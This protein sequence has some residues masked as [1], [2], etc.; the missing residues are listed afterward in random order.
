MIV[1][2]STWSHS[3]SQ[4][5]LELLCYDNSVSEHS[6][7]ED[8]CQDKPSTSQQHTCTDSHPSLIATIAEKRKIST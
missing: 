4:T 6:S 5:F 8:K 7:H 3:L 1:S 2:K